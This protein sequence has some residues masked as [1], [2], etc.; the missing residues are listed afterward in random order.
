VQSEVLLAD[1]REH[2]ALQSDEC[3]DER[4]QADEEANWFVF[5]RRPSLTGGLTPP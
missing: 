1:Q 3:A 5:A 4:V 2:A